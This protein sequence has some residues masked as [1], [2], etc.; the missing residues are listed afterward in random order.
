MQQDDP[1][2]RAG[3]GFRIWGH[4]R[5]HPHGREAASYAQSSARRSES[6][7]FAAGG[8]SVSY[9]PR[10]RMVEF[11]AAVRAA[12]ERVFSMKDACGYLHCREYRSTVDQY[13][14][15]AINDG[16]MF[17]REVNGAVYYAGVAISDTLLSKN[18]I[19]VP[20]RKGDGRMIP[21]GSRTPEEVEA[22][23]ADVRAPKVDPTWSPPKMVPPRGAPVPTPAPAPAP[24]EA[25]ISEGAGVEVDEQEEPDKFDAV[26]WLDGD[27]IIYGATELED[28]G[29]L[30]S[31][32]QLGRLKRLIAWSAA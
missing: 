13:I 5:A 32:D 8:A 25:S 23:L 19:A 15:A 2:Q 16:A 28:G 6:A 14:Y 1:Q 21:T 7:S 31:K 10:G 12:P 22:A 24:I 29:M 9:H 20:A 11:M 30:I 4:L 26:L 27:L 18:G 3:I 17:K